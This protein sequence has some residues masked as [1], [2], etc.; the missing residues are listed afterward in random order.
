MRA[1]RPT[2]ELAAAP[3]Q[4]LDGLTDLTNPV[5]ALADEGLGNCSYLVDLGDGGALVVDPSRDLRAVRAAAQ[6]AGLRIRFVADTHLH[7][8]FLSGA[9]QLAHD[10][11]AVVLAS[12]AGGRGFD[13]RGLADG[14]DVDLGGL[15]LA[16]LDTPGHTDEHLSFL[17]VDG[18]CS[19]AWT[20]S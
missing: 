4:V 19:C 5:S 3:G 16:A 6:R 13:H 1:R 9:V 17:L 10:E 18:S 15:S 7:A 2:H 20:S 8:D 12:A 11:G 14:D